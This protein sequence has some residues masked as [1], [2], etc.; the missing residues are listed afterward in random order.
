MDTI[1]QQQLIE[2][3]LHCR[4]ELTY[5]LEQITYTADRDLNHLIMRDSTEETR[6]KLRVD[7]ADLD[8]LIANLKRGIV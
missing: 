3:N 7:I 1:Q 8:Q 5:Q 6:A 2:L 4:A